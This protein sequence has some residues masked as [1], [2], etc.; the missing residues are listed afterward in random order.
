MG[1]P[2]TKRDETIQ[3]DEQ[4][5]DDSLKRTRVGLIIFV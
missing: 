2:P 4:E 1:L 3:R 5:Y